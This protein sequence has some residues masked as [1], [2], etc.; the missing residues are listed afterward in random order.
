[1]KRSLILLVVIVAAVLIKS[2]DMP[3]RQQASPQQTIDELKKEI[4]VL[5]QTINETKLIAGK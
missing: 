5:K 1:M 2:N 3:P 4:K